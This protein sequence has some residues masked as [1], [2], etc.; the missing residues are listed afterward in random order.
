[1]MNSLREK[2][3]VQVK[4]YQKM[5]YFLIQKIKK[6]YIVILLVMKMIIKKNILLKKKMKILMK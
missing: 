4:K 2:Q 3:Y 1:M 6:V 5:K